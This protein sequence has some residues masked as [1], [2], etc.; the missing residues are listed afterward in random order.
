[1]EKN[2]RKYEYLLFD[3]D[4]TLMDFT[5]GEKTA[6]FQ[7]MEELSIPL[8]EADYQRYLAINKAAWSRFE[9]G[10]L[11]SHAVQ[12][13]RFED[14]AAYLGF[15]ASQGEG[16]NARYVVNLGQQAI[17]L[18]GVMEMLTRL[19]QRYRLAIATN[20]LT[21]VQR[22]RL[23]KSGFLPLLSAVFI[24]QEMG[25]QKPDQAY[26]EYIFAAFSDRAREKYLMIGD[27][28]PADI[29]GGINAGIDTC[30]YHPAG[31]VV[32]EIAPTYTVKSFEELMALLL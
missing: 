8:S 11:D 32:P 13:V 16:M 31:T 3:L 21:L 18:P 17:L 12:R 1:M 28:L 30:W 25:V 2:P 19:S 26:Y 29:T 14:F 7:T 6:L 27:S 22:A 24:S 10:E 9:A 5:A 15:D 20:G 23:K 4:N